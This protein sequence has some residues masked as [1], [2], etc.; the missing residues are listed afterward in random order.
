MPTQICYVWQKISRHRPH[1]I[2][3]TGI[4]CEF[5]MFPVSIF[6]FFISNTQKN[7]YGY[8]WLSKGCFRLIS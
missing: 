6:S 3:V 8:F 7:K 4:L 2:Y 1:K 5:S